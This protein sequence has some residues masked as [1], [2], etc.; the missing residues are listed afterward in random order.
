MESQ[1]NSLST[2]VDRLNTLVMSV[3]GETE[4]KKCVVD[5]VV[6]THY[7]NLVVAVYPVSAGPQLDPKG[8]SLKFEPKVI[9]TGDTLQRSERL[10]H[11]INLSHILVEAY[12]L[13]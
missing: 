11:K 9:E 3:T 5:S 6:N 7:D 2:K 12:G 13:L 8:A 10:L 1:R 4:V